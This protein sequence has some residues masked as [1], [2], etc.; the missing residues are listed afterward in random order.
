MS[1]AP[2]TAFL[3]AEKS[4]NVRA[5]S[6]HGG[7]KR[8]FG[9]LAEVAP[10]AA[11]WAAERLFMTPPRVEAPEAERAALRAARRF[12]VPFG[13]GRVTA[14]FWAGAE[15]HPGRP[16]VLLIH[17]WGGRAGQLA[18]VAEHLVREGFSAVAFDA[19]A[20]G[21][22]DGRI[23]NLVEF[24]DA[25][26]AVVGAY[27]PV[28][29]TVA[30]SLGGAAAAIALGR[31]VPLGRTALI[32][33][34]TD[35]LAQTQRFADG[36]GLPEAV[37]ARM[38]R[39]LERRVG[40]P[41]RVF[42]LGV[43]PRPAEPLLVIHDRQDGEIPYEDG[44]RLAAAWQAELLTTD[45]LGHRRI[46]RAPEVLSRISRFLAADGVLART[47]VLKTCATPGCGRPAATGDDVWDGWEGYCATCALE[48]EL[49]TR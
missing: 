11:A 19:P 40:L 28:V 25:M 46:L 45:G 31:G 35:L 18:P 30:H 20:H 37:R 9:L 2:T 21:E 47:F 29:G 27:G 10:P 36:L 1:M 39:R 49:R 3:R 12:H 38:E 32:G 5:K 26:Q 48:L 16:T 4:T 33:A 34:P 44:R 22:S 6:G 13:R 14:W 41:L 42:N 17:G 43:Q 24:A 23:T 15:G 8:L 7:V